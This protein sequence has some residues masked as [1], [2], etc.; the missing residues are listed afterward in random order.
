MYRNGS[1]NKDLAASV[2]SQSRVI[3][4]DNRKYVDDGRGGGIRWSP[5]KLKLH[6]ELGLKGRTAQ[7]TRIC[8]IRAC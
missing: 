4:L 5:C 1:R 6:K 8:G 7:G 3:L 2:R